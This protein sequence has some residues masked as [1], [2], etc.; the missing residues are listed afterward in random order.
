MQHGNLKTPVLS[1]V[2]DDESVREAIKGFIQCIGFRAEIF[3]S[4]ENFLVSDILEQTTCLIVDVHMPVM[5]GLELQCRLASR[6][7]GIPIIFITAN[8][9]PT[10]RVQALKAGAVDFLRK[11]FNEDD[12][13]SAIQ[14]AL[15]LERD[16]YKPPINTLIGRQL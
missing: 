13:L 16:S 9:N 6:R 10:A 2:D 15:A 14:A 4:A 3:P 7:C 8:D 5:T 12:L 1:I 11:P